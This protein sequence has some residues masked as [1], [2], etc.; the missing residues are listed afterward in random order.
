MTISDPTRYLTTDLMIV[1]IT[2]GD[3]QILSHLFRRL[4]AELSQEK[5]SHSTDI[6]TTTSAFFE[7]TPI[8][9]YPIWDSEL[10]L[11]RYKGL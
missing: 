10:I 11:T 6:S 4:H 5:W 9:F 8:H 3:P 2:M 7:L 1:F